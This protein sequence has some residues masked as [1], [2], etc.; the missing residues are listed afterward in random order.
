MK[1]LIISLSIILI[2]ALF[3]CGP[4]SR[5]GEASV[6]VAQAFLM[7]DAQIEGY[8]KEFIDQS[9]KENTVAAAND[10]YAVRLSR[11]AGNIN[12]KDGIN[13]KVYKTK[14]IN[15]FACAD[16]S[17]RV[18]SGLMDIMSDEEVLGVI[19]HEI[20]HVKNKHTKEAFRNALMVSAARDVIASAG[21]T[22]A[23]LTDSQLGDIGAAFLSARFS[24]RQEYEADD[25]GYEFLK[26]NGLNPWAMSLSFQKLKSM[27]ESS[28]TP[29]TGAI[30]QLFSTHP[31]L[32]SRIKRMS[33]RATSEGYKKP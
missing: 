30:M 4:T 18:F 12:N 31:D 26:N 1:K 24:Q 14:D 8:T 17:V 9:D 15:A 11:I 23:V 33:D 5:V 16:G 29:K 25:Y 32:D 10:A 27:E 2:V 13:I 20:G 28:G 22:V 19:G 7:T 21:G 3:S 6:K